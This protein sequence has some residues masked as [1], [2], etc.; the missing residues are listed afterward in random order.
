[1]FLK[2]FFKL[3]IKKLIFTFVFLPMVYYLY[4]KFESRINLFEFIIIILL[5][6]VFSCFTVISLFVPNKNNKM[7]SFKIL[8]III[9]IIFSVLYYNKVIEIINTKL[10]RDFSGAPNCELYF[11]TPFIIQIK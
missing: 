5:S 1:M 11:H 4:Y 10:I 8:I 6:Y 3:N 7:P 9:L 2:E